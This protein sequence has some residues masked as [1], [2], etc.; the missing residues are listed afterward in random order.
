M[1]K[2]LPEDFHRKYYVA[3]SASQSFK[4]AEHKEYSMELE[5]LLEQ[6]KKKTRGKKRFP[7]WDNF[8]KPRIFYVLIFLPSKAR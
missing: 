8:N 6:K 2:T 7:G 1:R 4:N 3:T 5:E